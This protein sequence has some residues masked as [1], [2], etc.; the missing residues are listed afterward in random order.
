[1]CDKIIT[2]FSVQLFYQVSSI[3]ITNKSK[4]QFAK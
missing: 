4:T 2:N 3:S 1:M